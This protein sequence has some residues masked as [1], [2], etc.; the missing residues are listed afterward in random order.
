LHPLER[1]GHKQKTM[2]FKQLD[3]AIRFDAIG[4]LQQQLLRS[5]PGPYWTRVYE[6]A[7]DLALNEARS[8]F[9]SDELKSSQS[10]FYYR[11][12]DDAKRT[13]RRKREDE[14]ILASSFIQDDNEEAEPPEDYLFVDSLNPEQIYMRKQAMALMYLTC[15]KKHKYLFPVFNLMMKGYK[16]EET[17]QRLN[18]ST[19]L[20]KKLRSQIVRLAMQIL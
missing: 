11:L 18:I 10:R 3:A 19:A 15:F 8:V 9:T 13:L 2:I 16:V 20:V 14:P 7:L 1:S 12:I 5:E 4:K 6:K 17:A